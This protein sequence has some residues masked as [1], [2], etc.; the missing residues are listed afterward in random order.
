MFNYNLVKQYISE[1]C[2]S[3]YLSIKELVIETYINKHV[4]IK[5]LIVDL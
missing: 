1:I 5:Y 2:D 4:M 3:F